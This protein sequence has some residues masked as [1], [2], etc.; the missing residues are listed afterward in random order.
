LLRDFALERLSRSKVPR[1]FEI[2]ESLPR[3]GAGKL[4]RSALVAE[5]THDVLARRD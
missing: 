5:R 3:D 2:V 1:S 4:R